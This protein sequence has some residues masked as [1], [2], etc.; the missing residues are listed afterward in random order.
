MTT[1]TLFPTAV[2]IVTDTVRG[3][4]RLDLAAPTPCAEFDA[5]GLIGHFSGTAEALGRIGRGEPL[6]AE[7]P[8]GRGGPATEDWNL[9]LAASLDRL[10]E[11]WAEAGAWQGSVDFGTSEMPAE[12]VGQMAFAEAL[13]HG[14]DLARAGGRTFTVPEPV[15]AE[16]LRFVAGTA[17][18]GRTM[19][20]YGDEVTVPSDR[21]S[22]DR[23]LG[24]AGRNPAWPQPTTPEPGA[25]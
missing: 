10:G 20:A 14:W 12:A 7:N 19:G 4:D 3:L 24:Q 17:E 23:A 11:A 1:A 5:A 15:G 2:E 22:F 6:D 21:P 8:W 9:R 25:P 16:L 18:L 13:L